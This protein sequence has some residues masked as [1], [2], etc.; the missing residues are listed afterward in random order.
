MITQRF[1]P[2]LNE[3]LDF[4]ITSYEFWWLRCESRLEAT[5]YELRITSYWLQMSLGAAVFCLKITNLILTEFDATG[6]SGMIEVY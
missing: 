2:K 3:R 4:L 6:N 5:S 1:V